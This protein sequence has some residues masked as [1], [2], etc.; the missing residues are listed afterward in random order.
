M[1][2][3]RNEN[4]IV[5]GLD[6][7]GEGGRSRP[8]FSGDRSSTGDKKGNLSRCAWFLQKEPCSLFPN[9]YN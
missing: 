2:V 1:L 3:C 6:H 5:D 7:M 9:T 4:L 8:R